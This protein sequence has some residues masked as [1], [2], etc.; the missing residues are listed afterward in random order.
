MVYHNE[1]DTEVDIVLKGV[2]RSE[3]ITDPDYFIPF[4]LEKIPKKTMMEC[5]GIGDFKDSDD[6][7][8]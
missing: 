6:F 3:R 8:R 4:I 2:V 5:Y 1:N 7:I